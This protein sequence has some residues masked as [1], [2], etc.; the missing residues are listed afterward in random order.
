MRTHPATV[1]VHGDLAAEVDLEL[2]PLVLEIWRAGLETIHSCQDVGENLVDLAV[3]LPHLA[4]IVQRETG[5]A[6]IGF[7]HADAVMAF[8]DALANA[9]P[10]DEFYERMAHWA[11]PAAWQLVLAIQDRGLEQEEV[12][13]SDRMAPD[14]SLSRFAA[15]SFQVRFPRSDAAEMTQ[16]MRLHNRGEPVTLGRPTWAAIT[17][18][19]DPGADEPMTPHDLPPTGAF[20]RKCK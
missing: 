11:S 12:K 8:L 7:P 1:V 10:R 2:A 19:D 6:S 17:I 15:A 9:G 13:G 3:H 5:R 16:R 4:G 20:S 18:P 14:A